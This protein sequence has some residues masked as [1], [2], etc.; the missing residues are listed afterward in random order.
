LSKTITVPVKKLSLL[1]CNYKMLA[2][3]MV[4]LKY[5]SLSILG[6]SLRNIIPLV[7]NWGEYGVR[8]K[9]NFNH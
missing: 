3:T 8:A 6:H 1:H 7:G 5:G 2:S 4:E 9:Q